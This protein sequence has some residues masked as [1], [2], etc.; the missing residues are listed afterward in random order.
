MYM[1]KY[2]FTVEFQATKFEG[3]EVFGL[4][5]GW[6]GSWIGWRRDRPLVSGV[7]LALSSNI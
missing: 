6:I 3:R 7:D 2:S 4:S 5:I 1:S